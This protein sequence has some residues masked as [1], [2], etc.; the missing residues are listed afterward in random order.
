MSVYPNAK[1]K[2]VTTKWSWYFFRTCVLNF[3]TFEV[4]AAVLLKIQFFLDVIL[5]FCV[6]LTFVL[7]GWVPCVSTVIVLLWSWRQR[8]YCR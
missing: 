6:L 8:L 1:T 4:V 7:V 2:S 3:A 5:V